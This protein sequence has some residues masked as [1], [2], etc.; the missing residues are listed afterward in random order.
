MSPAS[1]GSNSM[2]TPGSALGNSTATISHDN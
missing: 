2:S 1:T